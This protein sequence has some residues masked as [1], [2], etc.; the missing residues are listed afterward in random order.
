MRGY[1]IPPHAR[2]THSFPLEK[3]TVSKKTFPKKGQESTSAPIGA[4][5][6]IVWVHT[7]GG[8]GIQCGAQKKTKLFII[9]TTN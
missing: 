2:L 4:N 6:D 7:L 8:G 3:G 9:R 5:V 1:C